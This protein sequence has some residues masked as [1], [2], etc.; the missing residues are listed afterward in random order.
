[1]AHQNHFLDVRKIYICY[2]S[3]YSKQDHVVLVPF[4]YMYNA[5]TIYYL[6]RDYP[7]VLVIMYYIIYNN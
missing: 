7:C 2:C 6:Y 1:M 4:P 5:I 3:I